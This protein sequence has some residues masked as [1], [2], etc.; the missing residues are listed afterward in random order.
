M[1]LGAK[2]AFSFSLAAA[3]F[4]GVLVFVIERTAGAQAVAV[5]GGNLTELAQQTTQRLE[6][7]L[8]ER[9]REVGLMADR[10]S[11][12]SEVTDLQREVDELQASYR[13]YAWVGVA[14]VQGIVL[15]ASRPPAAGANISG[16]PWFA[17]AL[18]GNRL[19]DVRA[20][21]E[22]AAPGAP[23]PRV[24]DIGFP[25]RD[26]GGAMTGLLGVQV[27]WDWARDLR[28]PEFQPGQ[29]NGV[30]P[31]IVSDDNVVLQGPAP[32]EGASVML[33][34][35]LR[36]RTEPAGYRL[37]RWA[38]GKAYVVGFSRM[39]G[40]ENS[41]GLGWTVL[42]RQDMDD[43]L[44]PVRE[45]QKRV[46]I[47]G[48]GAAML[49]GLLGWIAARRI[50]R[51]LREL[52]EATR[53]AEAGAAAVHV[54]PQG[55]REVQALG[56]AFDALTGKLQSLNSTLELR[57]AQRTEELELALAD[58]R[59]SERGMQSILDTSR[60]PFFGMDFEGRIVE[61]N[62]AAEA[63]FH[64]RRS[65]IVG[66]LAQETLVPAHYAPALLRQLES[67]GADEPPP[68]AASP[69][70]QVLMNREGREIPV[71]LRIGVARAGGRRYFAA[72]AWDLTARRTFER[73][74]SE[75]GST[76][77]Q[78]LSAPLARVH[79][80]VDL[81][82]GEM[83]DELPQDVRGIVEIAHNN[84]SALVRLVEDLVDLDNIATG[85]MRYRKDRQI[86]RPLVERAAR[87][88]QPQVDRRGIRIAL[89]IRGDPAVY[90]DADRIVQVIARLV[91]AAAQTLPPGGTVDVD[92]AEV[93]GRARIVVSGG[94]PVIGPVDAARAAQDE[95]PAEPPAEDPGLRVCASIV[96]AHAGSF[97]PN[98]EPGARSGY[99]VELPLVA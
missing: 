28:R 62:L 89:E 3:L 68:G 1:G 43:A 58:A 27:H 47:A 52:E 95:G 59:A 67:L 55:Y 4:A 82:A 36:S 16:R 6:R 64:W 2:L 61:W 54:Q 88:A 38:D 23:A 31:V 69:T 25:L 87:A 18:R 66:K 30:E 17:S 44:A 63:L 60:D 79:D 96:D 33:E 71:E 15:A 45:L 77:A 99:T 39:R 41:P 75:F 12:M 94:H 24:F 21:P 78:D 42:V 91:A 48:A 7:A 35:V 98:T 11:R 14:N 8:H 72:F 65:E 5:A 53:H 85:R 92:V 57:V 83:A 26:A 20:A 9:Y 97:G 74:K 90:G 19:G 29:R 49:F 22:L 93:R 81:L 76:L 32:L 86:L 56:Q 46:L 73:S 37:E 80:A 40:Y 34:S 10:L 70:E 51:P 84:S 13:F 50:A